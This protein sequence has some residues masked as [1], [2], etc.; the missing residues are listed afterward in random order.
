MSSKANL[1]NALEVEGITYLTSTQARILNEAK[2]PYNNL[3]QGRPNNGQ[4]MG[5]IILMLNLIDVKKSSTQ[6]LFITATHEAANSTFMTAVRISMKMNDGIKCGLVHFD[7]P[8]D[9]PEIVHCIFGTSKSIADHLKKNPEVLPRMVL[10]DDCNKSRRL[11]TMIYS[12][13]V[14]NT[15]VFQLLLREIRWTFVMSACKRCSQLFRR[16]YC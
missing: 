12:N 4:T 11:T 9:F 15:F 5:L 7:E 2:S 13:L 16:K 14:R 8:T 1:Q 10:F 3:I 6:I